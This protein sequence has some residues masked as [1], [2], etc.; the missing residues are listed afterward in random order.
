MPGQAASVALRVSVQAPPGSD[1]ERLEDMTLRL[2]REIRSLDVQSVER[3]SAGPLPAGAKSGAAVE[4]GALA[5][6]IG[7]KLVE[8]FFGLIKSWVSRPGNAGTKI[9]VG[10]EGGGTIT[11]DAGAKLTP[12]QI[13]GLIREMK[14]K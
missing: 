8:E 11:V 6:S 12:E 3:V 4:I 9:T 7:P 2:Q 14:R 1:P 5:I 13:R 10:V